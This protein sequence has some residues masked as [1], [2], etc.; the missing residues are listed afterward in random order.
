[1]EKTKVCLLST[2]M[3]VLFSFKPQVQ[4]NPFSWLK[5]ALTRGTTEA[6][7]PVTGQT[8]P[9][10]R[11]ISD[12]E[13][14]EIHTRH[15]SLNSTYDEVQKIRD[16]LKQFL[17][18][19]LDILRSHPERILNSHDEFTKRIYLSFVL[20]HIDPSSADDMALFTDSIIG[21]FLRKDESSIQE[22]FQVGLGG[23]WDDIETSTVYI[24]L[25]Y[26]DIKAGVVS[27]LVNGNFPYTSYVMTDVSR[28][29]FPYIAKLH[30]NP[31]LNLQPGNP[32]LMSIMMESLR[33]RAIGSPVKIRSWMH[34]IDEILFFWKYINLDPDNPSYKEGIGFLKDKI[35]SLMK[36]PLV[37]LSV[38]SPDSISSE[39]GYFFRATTESNSFKKFFED[40][41][42]PFGNDIRRITRIRKQL[43]QLEDSSPNEYNE[44]INS[45][46]ME[47]FSI[48]DWE[49]VLTNGFKQI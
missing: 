10:G 4:A 27:A 6:D 24:S 23:L 34:R 13:S 29:Y 14:L 9:G 7:V 26:S 32:T 18:S 1:M 30:T 48:E 17:N 25:N 15:H 42:R 19:P 12:E 41:F 35:K 2:F 3:M 39:L 46:A 5:K 36:P 31:Y 20:S 21:G 11:V 45:T 38:M 37:S 40:T 49:K 43:S 28:F 33:M 44:I 16:D 22:G 47:N 8:I